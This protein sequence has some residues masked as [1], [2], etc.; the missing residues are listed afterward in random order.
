MFAKM[1]NKKKIKKL[2]EVAFKNFVITK[3]AFV[4]FYYCIYKFFLKHSLNN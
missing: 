4:L 1:L 2:F 3:F